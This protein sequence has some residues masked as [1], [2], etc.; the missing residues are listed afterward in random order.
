MAPC[1][2]PPFRGPGPAPG[3]TAGITLLETLL[4]LVLIGILAA[5]AIP[6][7]ANSSDAHAVIEEARQIHGRLAEARARAIAEQRDTRFLLSS[8]SYEI[9]S[10]VEGTGWVTLGAAREVPESMTCTI[11]GNA[12]GSLVFEPHGRVDAPQS[13]VIEND[14]HEHT[15]HVLAGG[16]VRWEGQSQ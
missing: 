11:G 10:W 9:Q 12:S 7:I 14:D 3:G 15:I 8:G 13:I 4:V 6:S 2:R 1:A 5:V 16:L